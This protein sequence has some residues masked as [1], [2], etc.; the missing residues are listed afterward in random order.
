MKK[1]VLLTL[2]LILVLSGGITYGIIWY[3]NRKKAVAGSDEANTDSSSIL[4]TDI[5][6]ESAGT[7]NLEFWIDK[8]GHASFPLKKG[9]VGIEVYLVQIALNASVLNKGLSID[10]IAEDGIWGTETETRFKLEY[11]NKNEVTKAHFKAEFDPDNLI[12]KL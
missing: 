3:I 7:G 9:S 8:R 10:F 1:N 6:I 5:G 11:P 2:I 4:K 12:Q